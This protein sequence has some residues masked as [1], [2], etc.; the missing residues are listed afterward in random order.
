MCNTAIKTQNIFQTCKM[1][2][3]RVIGK[4][5]TLEKQGRNAGREGE[6]REQLQRTTENA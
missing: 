2:C 1:Q 5:I 6:K 4:H 3:K